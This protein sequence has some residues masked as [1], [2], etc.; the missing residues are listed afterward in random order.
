MT[1]SSDSTTSEKETHTNDLADDQ[2]SQHRFL[3]ELR[4]VEAENNRGE[5]LRQESGL[6]LDHEAEVHVNG[7]GECCAD[8]RE[9][10]SDAASEHQELR[11]LK[12]PLSQE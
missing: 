2:T 4:E 10:Q 3:R 12:Y 7:R 9:R 11:V 1:N 8:D 6:E 5:A